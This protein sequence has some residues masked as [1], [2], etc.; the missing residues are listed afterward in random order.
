MTYISCRKASHAYPY[1]DTRPHS[2]ASF[3]PLLPFQFLRCVDRSFCRPRIYTAAMRSVLQSLSGFRRNGH[4]LSR[5]ICVQRNM[6]TSS[7]FL[8]R[9]SLLSFMRT[10]GISILDFQAR[11]SI[12]RTATVDLGSCIFPSG[13]RLRLR[14]VEFDALPEK[15]DSL[16]I[17]R[18]AAPFARRSNAFDAGPV[19][20]NNLPHACFIHA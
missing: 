6:T 16:L 17:H 2:F 7:Y 4:I 3:C 9:I 5:P 20:G 18:A 13:S 15:A 11:F 10:L 19:R 1:Q 14:K 8:F 12:N